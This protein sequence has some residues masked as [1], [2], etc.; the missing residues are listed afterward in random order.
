MALEKVGITI[1][2]PGVLQVCCSRLV[3]EPPKAW[4]VQAQRR[5]H[6][7]LARG[8]VAPL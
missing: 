5:E 8:R 7:Q 1:Q 4:Q 3:A 2:R 6:G